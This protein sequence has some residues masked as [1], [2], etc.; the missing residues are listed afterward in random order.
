MLRTLGAGYFPLAQLII[1]R[2][3]VYYYLCWCPLALDLGG[4]T[5]CTI[6]QQLYKQ[7]S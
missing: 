7:Y 6:L 1:S 4:N 2:K 5:C 3:Y